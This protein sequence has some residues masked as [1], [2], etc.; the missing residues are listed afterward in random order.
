MTNRQPGKN[1]TDCLIAP[2]P[3]NRLR[4]PPVS[5]FFDMCLTFG[6]GRGVWENLFDIEFAC[7]KVGSRAQNLHG[8]K[9]FNVENF[10]RNPRFRR[11]TPKTGPRRGRSLRARVPLHSCH[12]VCSDNSVASKSVLGPGCR[13]RIDDEHK[14]R[15]KFYAFGH[16]S[17]V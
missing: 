12:V 17:G 3:D 4:Y 1:Q 15:E 14:V 16:R 8:P 13:R 9:M 11:A 6:Q 7:T 10:D 2:D 5:L